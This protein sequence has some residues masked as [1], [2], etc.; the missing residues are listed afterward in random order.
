MKI[1]SFIITF[2]NGHIFEV[3]AKMVAA[4]RAI[5]FARRDMHIRGVPEGPLDEAAEALYQ[6]E[7]R[8]ASST[9]M[10]LRDW[11]DTFMVWADLEPFAKRIDKGS[12]FD[13]AAEF[14][15]AKI[16]AGSYAV[17]T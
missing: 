8:E 15:N 14:K 9:M 10:A 13:Y 16:K 17:H 2:K 12:T 7:L 6:R 1:K 11:M 4:H 3:P 5:M